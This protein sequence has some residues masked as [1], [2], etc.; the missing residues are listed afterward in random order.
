[1]PNA[2]CGGVALCKGGY[3]TFA[4]PFCSQPCTPEC[5]PDGFA[6]QAGT[7]CVTYIGPITTYTCAISPCFEMVSCGCVEALCAEK[8]M[9]CN[10]IQDGYKVLCD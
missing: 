2:C 5:G 7:L 6:C 1:V 10:N 9:T 4:G 8:M 3:W